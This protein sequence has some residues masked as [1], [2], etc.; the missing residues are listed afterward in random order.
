MGTTIAACVG[1]GVVAGIAADDQFGTSPLL[2]IV[3]LVLGA[4]AAGFA[5]AAQVRRF[6]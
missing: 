4:L 1:V 2:L 5:V 6:L 3:G